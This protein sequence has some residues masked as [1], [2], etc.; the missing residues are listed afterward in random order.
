MIGIL[1]NILI[2]KLIGIVQF[3][4]SLTTI[5]VRL[6][7]STSDSSNEAKLGVVSDIEQWTKEVEE[8]VAAPSQVDKTA[9][10]TIPVGLGDQLWFGIT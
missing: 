10:V 9:H 8:K 3:T 2:N 5:Y 1:K 7:G 6:G 4:T